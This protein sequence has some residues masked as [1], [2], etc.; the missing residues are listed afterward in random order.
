[1]PRQSLQPENLF[2]SAPF[3]FAQVVTSSGARH[4][5]CAGQTAWDPDMQL[6]G[7]DDLEQQLTFALENVRIALEAGGA[8]PRDIVRLTVYVVDYRPAQAQLI[9]TVLAEFLDPDNLPAAT[10]LGVQSLAFPEFLVEVEATAVV[11]G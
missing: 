10:L 7:G 11:D 2:P 5:H 6:V 4:V 9:G 8:A 3:A 1:M